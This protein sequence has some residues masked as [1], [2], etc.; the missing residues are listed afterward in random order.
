MSLEKWEMLSYVVTVFGLPVAIIAYLLEKRKEREN[1]ED[2]VHQL[3]SDNYQEF[4]TTC[5]DNP[6]LHLFSAAETPGLTDEQREKMF[7]IFSM[8]VALFERAY[9]LM[10]EKGMS[11]A[12]SRRWAAWEDYMREWCRREDFRRALSTLLADEDPEF[13]AHIEHLA[14]RDRGLQ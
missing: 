9:V 1:R 7:I 4:L 5:L 14:A 8:L 10:Y 13:A 2:E 11:K 3:L 12:Q 6:D